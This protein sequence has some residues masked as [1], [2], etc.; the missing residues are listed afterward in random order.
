ML[1]NVKAAK[2]AAGSDQVA[3]AQPAHSKI[4]PK[5]FAAETYQKKPRRHGHYDTW[6]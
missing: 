3:S 4:S 6:V 5:K 2:A 1:Q